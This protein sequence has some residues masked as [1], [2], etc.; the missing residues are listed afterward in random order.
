MTFVYFL[1]A[2]A[3]GPVKIGFS[4]HLPERLKALQVGGGV[5]V[6]RVIEGGRQTEAWL[7]QHFAD[8]RRIGEWF[9]FDPDMLT[10]VP[11]DEMPSPTASTP[12]TLEPAL[13]AELHRIIEAAVRPIN[14]GETVTT[15]LRRAAIRLGMSYQRVRGIWYGNARLISA[16]EIDQM[17][18]VA[19]ALE[20][21]RDLHQ[22]GRP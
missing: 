3:N 8:L 18:A 17:R 6:I 10:I 20:I 11:P 9:A 19:H 5:G 13:Q 7:H 14:M 15:L 4:R 16:G 1:Q 2:G 12:T 22:E 21:E